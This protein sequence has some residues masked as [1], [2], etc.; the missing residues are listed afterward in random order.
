[1]AAS[2]PGPSIG[3]LGLVTA[4]SLKVGESINLQAV[5]L[6]ACDRYLRHDAGPSTTHWKL[7]PSCASIVKPVPIEEIVKSVPVEGALTADSLQLEAT[8]AG[9]CEIEIE[10][11]GVSTKLPVTVQPS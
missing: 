6:D 1:V 5:R 11:S 4:T 8:G 3:G 9:S 2:T 7:A 10:A